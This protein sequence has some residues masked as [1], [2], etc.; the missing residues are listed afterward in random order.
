MT[1]VLP[2]EAAQAALREKHWQEIERANGMLSGPEVSALP[3]SIREAL[4]GVR[5]PEGMRYPRFQVVVRDGDVAVPPA[6]LQLQDMLAPARWNDE[7]LLMWTLSVNGW[8]KGDTPAQEIQ[9]H[10]DGLTARLR[11]AVDR[12]IP[13]TKKELP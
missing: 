9:A 6:W 1:K 10:P 5:R 13:W 4:L 11:V 8:L 7:F 3:Q 12:A 2:G